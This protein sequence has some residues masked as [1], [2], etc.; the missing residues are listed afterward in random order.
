M[1]LVLTI[2]AMLLYMM[3]AFAW[4]PVVDPYRLRIVAAG[5]FC[6]ALAGLFVT[7]F[8]F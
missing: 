3:A 5:L 7:G 6:Q 8:K 1:V 2:L 4:P